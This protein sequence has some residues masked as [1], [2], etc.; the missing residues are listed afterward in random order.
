MAFL[1]GFVLSP[2]ELAVAPIASQAKVAEVVMAAGTSSITEASPFVVRTSFT[3]AQSSVPM[4]EWAVKNGI[5]K[6][7]TLVTDYGPGVDPEK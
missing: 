2:I 1:A 5:K 4:A 6:V 3:L 7:V